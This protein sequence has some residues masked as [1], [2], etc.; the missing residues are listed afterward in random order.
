MFKSDEILWYNNGVW[1]ELGYACPNFGD[2]YSTLNSN[3][4][5][6]VKSIGRNLQAVMMH[7]DA[8]LTV[9]PTIN[10]LTRVH[11]LCT[12]ARSILAARAVA[13]ATQR[14]EAVHATP[15]REDFLIYPLPYWKV[16]NGWLKEW[17]GLMLNA[18]GEA[19]QHTENANAYDVSTD[20]AGLIGQ[21]VQRVYVRMATELFGVPAAEAA[22]PTFTLSD[23]QLKSYDPSKFFTSTELI[24]TPPA[25]DSIPTEDDLTTLTNGIPASML[26]GL[27]KYPRGT[28]GSAQ[29]VPAT[30]APAFVA[31]PSP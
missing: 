19:C 24:D 26:V 22:A 28:G 7:R 30:T 18:I 3:I 13:P 20:F 10:T 4:A 9:P 8:D 31:P 2:D 16:R 27:T 25:F 17:A 5:Y 14:F 15:A 1:G 21:Y 12:R 6:L 11:K 29:T 23:A